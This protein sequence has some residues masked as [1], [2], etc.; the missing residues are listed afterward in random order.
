MFL[1]V[2]RSMSCKLLENRVFFDPSSC[3][4]DG[5]KIARS[6]VQPRDCPLKQPQAK[7]EVASFPASLISTVFRF[8]PT[9][10]PHHSG[11]LLFSRPCSVLPERASSRPEYGTATIEQAT[12]RE[13]SPGTPTASPHRLGNWRAT[14]RPTTAIAANS[15]AG[16]TASRFAHGS[17]SGTLDWDAG[18][19]GRE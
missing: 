5:L 11:G 6:P 1:F 10:S 12:K 9:P 14:C 18:R 2:Q 19:T 4:E 15:D 3:V 13:T 8:V 16:G 7:P 17:R